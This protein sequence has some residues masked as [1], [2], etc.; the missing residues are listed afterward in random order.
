MQPVFAV[1]MNVP[2]FFLTF[3]F[4]E[5]TKFNIVLNKLVN[6]TYEAARNQERLLLRIITAYYYLDSS[7]SSEDVFRDLFDLLKNFYDLSDPTF[8]I[9]LPLSN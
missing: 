8:L 1:P 9:I 6:V 5:S 3:C 7:S 2:L 4:F